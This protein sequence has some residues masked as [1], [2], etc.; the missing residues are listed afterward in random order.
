DR[1]YSQVAKSVHHAADG[2]EPLEIFGEF[3]RVGTLSVQGSERVRNA[4]LPQIVAGGH[5]AAEAVAAVSDR[6]FRGIVRRG[7][8]EHRNA[9]I[10][11]PQSIRNRALLAEV[12]QSHNNPVDAVTVA[13]EK[14]GTS[15]R[16][17]PGLD[18]AVLA[19]F[20]SQ[21][22]DIDAGSAQHSQHL[23]PSALGQMIG[24]ETAVTHD[25]AHRHPLGRHG[26]PSQ[27]E[28]WR[29]RQESESTAAPGSTR[30]RGGKPCAQ[31]YSNRLLTASDVY[32]SLTPLQLQRFLCRAEGR[33]CTRAQRGRRFSESRRLETSG[34]LF[35]RPPWAPGSEAS[36]PPGRW[37]GAV[38]DW[39]PVHSSDFHAIRIRLRSTGH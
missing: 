5:L 2:R 4:V 15:A 23:L 21:S 35:P 24:K 3:G 8:N 38:R 16:L 17:L 25:Q 29:R 34:T 19:L 39:L 11:E 36:L 13:P 22:D 10:G 12:G 33:F 37:T 26:T 28:K 30:G 31:F 18:S 7:L 6:H 32:L 27:F 14:I 20:R 9:Q 1:S